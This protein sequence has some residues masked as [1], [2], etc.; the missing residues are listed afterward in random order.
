MNAV[1]LLLGHRGVR[2]VSSIGENT[3]SAFDFA[4]QHGCDGFEFDVRLT[5]DNV[6][7][8]CHD[9]KSHGLLICEATAAQLAYLP[10]LDDVLARYAKRAFLDIELKVAGLERI[11]LAAVREHLP[12]RGFVVSSFLPEVL[13]ELRNRNDAI[14]L[15][16]ICDKKKAL[17]R[18]RELSVEHV[19]P[20]HSLVTPK[21]VSEIHDANKKLFV[22]T[23]NG[24]AAMLRFASCV[25]GI[26]SDKPELLVRALRRAR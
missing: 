23:V 14:P 24:K 17:R 4:L 2:Y 3:T 18:W 13:I 11:T 8:V 16:L 22:W 10:R 5:R 26:I 9:A 19:I 7:V 1:P 21:L 25:H 20:H 15:G 6:A 12:A